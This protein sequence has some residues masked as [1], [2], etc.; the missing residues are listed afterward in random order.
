M[1]DEAGYFGVNFD[2]LRKTLY[3]MFFGID[4]GK[5]NDFKSEKYKY[6][7]PMQG[8]FDNPLE[9]DEAKDTFIL[10]WI[11]E[12]K[13]LTQ[14]SYSVD[15]EGNPVNTQKCVA[16]ILLRFVGK[17][18]ETWAKSLRHMTKRSDVGKIFSGVCNAEKLEYTSPIIP[19]KVNYFGKNSQ[20]AFDVRFKL[21][22]DEYI[23]INWLPLKGIDF[24]V[25]GK[26]IVE[27]TEV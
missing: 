19:Q 14:D 25:E 22:Y 7:L 4:D 11:V 18:A 23:R 27:D 2:N 9:G 21:Y 15:G 24:K 5:C 17:K 10:F 8:N 1:A 16:H 20:V 12:D 6:I 3:L 26:I 13:S